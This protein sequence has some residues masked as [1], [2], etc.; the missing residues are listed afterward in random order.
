L[1]S[2]SMQPT[3]LPWPC[4]PSIN[5]SSKGCRNGT[6][7]TAQNSTSTTFL[8]GQGTLQ[9]L[10]PDPNHGHIL[11]DYSKNL[12]ME[13]VMQMLVNLAKSRGVEAAQ[14]HMFRRKI[15]FTE[16]WAV[17]HMALQNRS[18]APIFVDRKD[19]TL[20][21]NR[22]L[23]KMNTDWKESSG[24]V[25]MNIILGLLMVTDTLRLYS[26]NINGPHIA[27]TL[28]VLNP[29]IPLFIITSKILTI[30]ETIT[31]TETAKRVVSFV[32]QKNLLRFQ[33][34]LLPRVNN[35]KQ[36]FLGAHWMDNH[37]RRKSLEKNTPPCWLWWMSR[38]LTTLSVRSVQ[39]GDVDPMGSPKSSTCVNHQ[40]GPVMWGEPGTNGQHAFY[41]LVL[42]STNM[43]PSDFHIPVQ[44]QHPIRK[45]MQATGKNLT[46]FEKLLLH[47]LTPFILG[48]LI[49]V[50][51]YEIFMQSVNWNINSFDQWR[52]ELGTQLTKKT[53]PELHSISLVTSHNSSTNRLI[54]FI[55]QA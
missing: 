51:E 5:N 40:T 17:L 8:K 41:Q 3:S 52:V 21:V 15:N 31:N 14:D 37:F 24:K 46:D 32:G 11:L 42:Q 26:S 23:E 34:T 38:A 4:L 47:K 10:Q 30:Q 36:L 49:T 28:A 12:E 18:I 13:N 45:E 39:Q 55:K 6:A 19:A 27:K 54:N 7:R 1:T 22:V 9:P 20:E 35:F 43:I 25:F 44:T 53:E 29:E 33:S 2:R 50:C 16:D 48:A